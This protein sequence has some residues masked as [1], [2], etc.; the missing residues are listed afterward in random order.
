MRTKQK[1]LILGILMIFFTAI[2]F[3]GR[4]LNVNA[5]RAM[6]DVSDRISFT[7]ADSQ[8]DTFLPLIMQGSTRPSE[9]KAIALV[10][11]DSEMAAY[12]EFF[13]GWTAEA[14]QEDGDIWSVDVF[15]SDGEW[16][17]YGQVNIVT[18][19]ILEIYAPMPLTPEEF[20]AG[21]EAARGLVLA[22][23]E[24][25]ALLGDPETWEYSIDYNRYDEIWDMYFYRGLDAWDV[26]VNQYDGEFHL[27]QIVDANRMEEQEALRWAKDQAIELAYSAED[28]WDRLDGIDNWY[29]FVENQGGSVWSVSFTNDDRVLFFALVNIDTQEILESE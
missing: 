18:E 28:V 20:Q 26:L 10:V 9:E 11:A 22:D 15:D 7:Q 12:L 5:E 17:G 8:T 4:A 3:G 29:T 25:L 2:A 13:P 24:V 14:Y 16:Q 23:A 6:G 19:E 1:Y 27:D 21:Q